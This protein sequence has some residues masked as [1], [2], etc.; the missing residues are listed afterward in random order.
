M[1]MERGGKRAVLSPVHTFT[2]AK[3][4]VE[5][6]LL[7]CIKSSSRPPLQPTLK[8]STETMLSKAYTSINTSGPH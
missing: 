7:K 4:S 3:F 8:H 5:F 6:M 1:C 2:G